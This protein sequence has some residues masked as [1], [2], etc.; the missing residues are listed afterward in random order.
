VKKVFGIWDGHDSGV[1]VVEG[2]KILYASN[3]ERFSRQKLEVGFPYLSFEDAVACCGEPDEIVIS[4]TDPSKV[5]TR[6]F[7]CLGKNYYLFRRHR[8]APSRFDSA[9]SWFKSFATQLPPMAGC[10]ALTRF[11]I[12]RRTGFEKISVRTIDHHEAHLRSAFFTSPF[13]SATVISLDG[14]G[15]ACSGAVAVGTEGKMELITRISGRDSIALLYEEATRL[16]N[17][18]ELE[19]EGKV[20]ALAAHAD[21]GEDERS[22]LDEV[23]EISDLNGISVKVNRNAYRRLKECLWRRGPE[24]FAA[25]VQRMTERAVIALVKAAVKMTG[26]TNVAVAGGLFS[27]VRINRLLREKLFEDKLSD[28]WVFPNMGDGGLALGAALDEQ[29]SIQ[30]FLGAEIDCDRAV[31]IARERGL[32]V[33][34]ISLEK[35]AERIAK[36]ESIGWVNGRMEYGPRALGARSILARPDDRTIRDRLNLAQKKRVFFQPFCPTLTHLEA[37]RS[38]LNYDGRD[39]RWMTSLYGTNAG[40]SKRLEGVIG[41]DGSCR[42]Q[43]LSKTPETLE[44]KVFLELVLEV[45]KKIGIGGVLNTSF[46]IHGDPIVRT[47]SDAIDAFLRSGLSSLVIGG[48]IEIIRNDD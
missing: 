41:P 33:R 16:L 18:R 17:L 28:I 25:M 21:L 5:L 37:E 7:P 22:V 31:A 32:N 38:L 45:E 23:I 26:I 48:N 19:D 43:I 9:K 36:G 1:A 27:N 42:P 11:I 3:E 24:R 6:I 10:A 46:N 8:I 20:M 39:E 40:G 15:D 29:I 13:S 14:I 47:E 44:E 2:E 35:A 12:R 4:T 34:N 30:P